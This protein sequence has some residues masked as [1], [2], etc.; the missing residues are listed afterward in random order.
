MR[1]GCCI[2]TDQRYFALT[3]LAWKTDSSF[4]TAD[5]IARR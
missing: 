4:G 3:L 1:D 5:G 2:S